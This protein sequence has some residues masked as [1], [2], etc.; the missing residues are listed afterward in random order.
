[1]SRFYDDLAPDHHLIFDDWE[2]SLAWQG[3]VLTNIIQSQWPAHNTVLDVSCGIGTQVLAL[4]MNG[5]QVTGS[6]LSPRAVERARIEAERRNHRTD[7]TVCDMR[8]AFAHHG[9]GFDLVISCD[10]SIPHLLT[11][12]DISTALGQMFACLR[13][14][15]GCLLTVRDYDQE[16]RGKNIIK[17]IRAF[18]RNSV[19]NLVVQVWDFE[20]DHYDVTMFILEETLA[21]HNVRTR[22]M[23]S[24]YYAIGVNSIL[25]MM[26]ATGFQRATRLDGVFYQPVLVGTKPN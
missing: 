16:P 2:T 17:P 26:D 9:G 12:A 4:A 15:G 18:T 7:L 5:F 10:N 1:V 19:R 22:K 13:P 24:R 20:K 6:D 23:R 11:D 3:R 21:S 8:Q 14:G 25:A